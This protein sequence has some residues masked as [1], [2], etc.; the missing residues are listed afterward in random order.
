MSSIPFQDVRILWNNFLK[1]FHIYVMFW[2]ITFFGKES[3]N[4]IIDHTKT[5]RSMETSRWSIGERQRSCPPNYEHSTSEEDAPTTPTPPTTPPILDDDDHLSMVHAAIVN[6]TIPTTTGIAHPNARASHRNSS[7]LFSQ[8]LLLSN[9][10]RRVRSWSKT[11]SRRRKDANESAPSRPTST[12]S[13]SA[14]VAS[15]QTAT[16]GQT[17]K[18]S[19]SLGELKTL[20]RKLQRHFTTTGAKI[21]CAIVFFLLWISSTSAV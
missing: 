5:F 21:V 3:V 9:S 7:N 14:A 4:E 18:K 17:I 2:L 16:D 6:G 19:S 10:F 1:V 8:P 11:R 13:A 15:H 12:P 20:C